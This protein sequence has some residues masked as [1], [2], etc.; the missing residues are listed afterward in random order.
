MAVESALENR[1]TINTGR[2]AAH[3]LLLVTSFIFIFPFIYIIFTA[4]KTEM[5]TLQNPSLLYFNFTFENFKA[6]TASGVRII[7]YYK[8]SIILTVVSTLFVIILSSAGGYGFAKY[9]FRTRKLIMTTILLTMTFPLGALLIPMYIMEFKLG[10]SDTL[11]GLIIPNIAVNV[12]FGF[13]IMQAVFKAMPNEIIDY[14]EIDGCGPF[15][16]WYLIM[17]PIAKN[18]ILAT[19]ILCFRSVWG[20]FTIARTLASSVRSLPL[21]VGLTELKGEFWHFGIMSAIIL[22]AI[23]PPVIIFIIFRNY[24]QRGIAVGSV[25]G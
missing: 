3:L 8:N 7:A 19:G 5:D 10:F 2:L 16:T 18:G 14:A 24:F 25:K 13:F 15:K 6:I 23:L 4:F 17:V 9:R 22:M 21:S 20:E 1:K 11:I 12:P